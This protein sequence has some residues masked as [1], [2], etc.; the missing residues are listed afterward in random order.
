MAFS[1]QYKKFSQGGKIT[2]TQSSMISMCGHNC[3]QIKN[4]VQQCLA[5][6]ELEEIMSQM[7]KTTD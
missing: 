1:V 5:W 6:P 7:L 2:A 3:L 4:C